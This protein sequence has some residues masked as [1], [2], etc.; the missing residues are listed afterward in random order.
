MYRSQAILGAQNNR[1]PKIRKTTQ[2]RVRP[3]P[4]SAIFGPKGTLPF[5]I[6]FVIQIEIFPNNQ[7][8]LDPLNV[9]RAYKLHRTLTSR[10]WPPLLSHPP[11]MLARVR[12]RR[13]LP[14]RPRRCRWHVCIGRELR[15]QW[16]VVT[17]DATSPAR[18]QRGRDAARW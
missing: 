11:L 4:P 7:L 17:T 6:A 9:Y 18:S 16:R 15:H 14:S 8:Q 5:G 10:S 13:P 2:K 1:R 3:T 12:A